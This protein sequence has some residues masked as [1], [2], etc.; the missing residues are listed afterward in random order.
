MRST[1]TRNRIL[2]LLTV[3]VLAT[4]LLIP[5]SALAERTIALS[6]GAFDLA[7]APGQSSAD[8]IGVAN[9]GDEPLTALVYTA[10][11][12][13]DETGEQTYVR[14]GPDLTNFLTSPASWVRVKVPD[15]TKIVANT[16]YLEMD[17]GQELPVDFEL[18]VPRNAPPGDYNIV[19][20][21]EMFEFSDGDQGAIS[22]VS[23]RIGSRIDLRVV[24]DVI[25]KVVVG[26]FV[27]QK[28][29]I[30]DK[31]SFSTKVANE[32]NIDKKIT[33]ELK[34]VGEGEEQLWSKR[35]DKSA[36]LYA[37]QDRLYDGTVA[38]KGVGF[39]KYTFRTQVEYQRELGDEAR[40]LE[41]VSEKID[42]TI[43]I[44]PLWL[45]V[46]MI[47]LVGLPLLYLTYRASTIG[48][49]R[50]LREAEA[51]A[52]GDE[53]D[54][55]VGDEPASRSRASANGGH[56]LSRAESRAR[57]EERRR[58]RADRQ[59]STEAPE[60]DSAPEVPGHEGAL[61]E[62]LFGDEDLFEEIVPEDE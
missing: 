35:L 62:S 54:V 31:T 25:D 51:A 57:D 49:R 22:R 15:S 10:D 9:N 29:V 11:V 7:L 59:A 30:G 50:K 1:R 18:V 47:L 55:H 56:H 20:F 45:A 3:A 61:T 33:V 4:A 41:P 5:S 24:G 36:N 13:A 43:W 27:A 40:T 34:L 46:L 8:R 60:V 28:L 6:T 48:I 38:F 42:R 52:Q 16:P 32:G 23:G 53:D 37:K 2:A 21:F 39:G 26:P 44:I 17:P 58:A 12:K 14:P 19:V